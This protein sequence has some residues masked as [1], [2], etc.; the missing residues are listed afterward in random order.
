MPVIVINIVISEETC[1]F[2]SDMLLMVLFD[3]PVKVLGQTLSA[4]QLNVHRLEI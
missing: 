2:A 1:R 4:S 3:C